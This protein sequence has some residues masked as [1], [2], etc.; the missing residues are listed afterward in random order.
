[1]CG[2]AWHAF[3]VLHPVIFNI[4]EIIITACMHSM[5]S[6]GTLYKMKFI[7]HMKDAY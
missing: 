4:L 2:A 3:G 6:S 5:Q 1:M 7:K